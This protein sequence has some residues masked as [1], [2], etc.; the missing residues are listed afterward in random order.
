MEAVRGTGMADQ[1]LSQTQQLSQRQILAPMLRHSLE[2][3]QVPMMELQTLVQLELQQ[4]PTL[5]EEITDSM[6]RL[7][8]EPISDAKEEEA[9]EGDFDEQ[10]EALAKLDDEFREY[11]Q[12]ARSTPYT[13]DDAA[14]RQFFLD[15]LSKPESLQEH[16][17][18]QL[19]LS[20]L[21]ADDFPLGELLLG[22]IND[23]GYMTASIGELVETTG[24]AE[25]DVLRMLSFIQDFEPVGVAARDL[26]ECLLLQ[27]RRL[28]LEDGLASRMVR[29]HLTAVAA[30]KYAEIARVQKVTPEEVQAAAQFIATL[31]PKPGRAFESI[32]TTYV[33]PEVTITRSEGRYV[34]T[35]NNDQMP[36]LHISRHYRQLMGDASTTR[37]VKDFIRQKIQAGEFLIKSIG[38]RQQT[39]SRISEEIVKVQ[40]EFLEHGVS[41]LRPLTMAEIAD[42]LGIHETT[43]SR[44]IANKYIQTPRGTFEMKYFFTPGFKTSDGEHVSNKTIKDQIMHMVQQE[45]PSDP[46]SDQRMVEMLRES[47]TKVARRTVAKYRDELKILPSH[48]RRSL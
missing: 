25:A 47:G 11:F 38:Q 7:E 3:L 41:R 24:Y 48:L 26:R 13:A 28:G 5:E 16:L 15:S 4:N 33:L 45:D 14:R 12:Q 30:H 10:F 43:V 6:D 34:V 42:K 1:Y 2:M 17:L 46:L 35:L 40:E 31:E 20:N 36:H 44:A 18:V 37:E 27:L 8:V 39:I 23:D 9:P 19:Q 21:P 29:D 22:N 32:A